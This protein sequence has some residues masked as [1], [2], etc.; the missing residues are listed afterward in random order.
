MPVATGWGVGGGGASGKW[1]ATATKSKRRGRRRG[2]QATTANTKRGELN[3][4]AKKKTSDTAGRR[5][6]IDSAGQCR[7]GG[8]E[9]EQIGGLACAVESVDSHV[10]VSPLFVCRFASD[11]PRRAAYGSAKKYTHS[12][13]TQTEYTQTE[14]TQI[15]HT[16]MQLARVA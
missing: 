13:H 2:S 14:Y 12:A 15:E 8:R 9:R 11:S 16:H 1:D 7:G 10:E 3:C 4:V 6:L 5:R